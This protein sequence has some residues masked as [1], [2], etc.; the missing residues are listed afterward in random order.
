[1]L[2]GMPVC[3]I[4]F[5]CKRIREMQVKKEIFYL[6]LNLYGH[7]DCN[8]RITG[9]CT[10]RAY[11]NVSSLWESEEMEMGKMI[12][13]LFNMQEEKGEFDRLDGM[14]SRECEERLQPFG[15]ALPLFEYE[16][17]RDVVFSIAYLAKKS[18]FETGVKTAMG[19]IL[20]CREDN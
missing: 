6:L 4:D 8:G 14:L 12:D 1:M 16:R 10:N 2:Q 13:G 11:T 5:L 18:A 20:E 3:N 7:Q 9:E 19:L 17:M 15:Q